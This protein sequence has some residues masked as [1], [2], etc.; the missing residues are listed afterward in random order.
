VLCSLSVEITSIYA[1]HHIKYQPK[2]DTRV[3]KAEKLLSALETVWP[4]SSVRSSRTG[5]AAC[6]GSD[7]ASCTQQQ[8]ADS[9]TVLAYFRKYV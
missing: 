9:L 1:A 8:W 4:F 6:N 2:P 5:C 7:C 3:S